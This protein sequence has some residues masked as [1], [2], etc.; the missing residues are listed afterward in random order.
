MCIEFITSFTI[1]GF[2]TIHSM[3]QLEVQSTEYENYF[4]PNPHVIQF[5]PHNMRDKLNNMIRI[6]YELLLLIHSAGVPW[7]CLTSVIV[8][9]SGWNDRAMPPAYR[10]SHTSK[11][12]ALVVR[13]G[14]ELRASYTVI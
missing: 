8:R 2:T 12:V 5:I 1:P 3:F 4:I 14:V 6:L 9:M 10:L 11:C 13:P 7:G